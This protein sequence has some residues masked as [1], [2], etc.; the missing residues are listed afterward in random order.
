MNFQVEE[1][2]D[3]P[4]AVFEDIDEQGKILLSHFLHPA[5]HFVAEVLYE[6]SLVERHAIEFSGF[7]TDFVDVQFFRDRVVIKSQSK[8]VTEREPL[9]FVLSVDEAKLLLLEWGAKIQRW[10]MEHHKIES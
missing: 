2:N 9:N 7:E 6:L 5:P 8:N 10:R 4:Q 1:F 3:L